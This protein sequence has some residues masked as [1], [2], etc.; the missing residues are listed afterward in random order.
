MPFRRAASG[1]R[2]S[3]DVRSVATEFLPL[4]SWTRSDCEKGWQNLKTR[5]ADRAAR[6]RQRALDA[7]ARLSE[8]YPGDPVTGIFDE[9]DTDEAAKRWDDFRNAEPCPVLDPLTGTCELYESRPVI[10]RTFGPALKT[11][12]DLGHCELCFVGATEEEVIASEMNPDPENLEAALLDE[13]QKSH[14]RQRG[15]DYRV[16][17]GKVE[18]Q[19]AISSRTHANLL[20]LTSFLT[21]CL[22]RFCQ[23]ASAQVPS[24][25]CQLLPSLIPSFSPARSSVGKA[26]QPWP[27]LRP[28]P[29]ERSPASDRHWRLRDLR[30]GLAWL[31]AVLRPRRHAARCWR[32]RAL[33]DRKVWS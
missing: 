29:G 8:D 21:P 14:R 16:C 32:I 28:F 31:A 2:A 5:D 23:V 7:V 19:L 3:P 10:C 4:I 27:G 22:L 11:D 18:E 13:L 17:A 12:G 20:S 25:K 6:I 26:C 9:D 24:A 30:V 33:Q 1:W 15:N